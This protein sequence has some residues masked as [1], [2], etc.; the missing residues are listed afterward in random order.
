MEK[1]QAL[2]EKLFV[3]P[4]NI[5]GGTERDIKAGFSRFS[6]NQLMLLNNLYMLTR[7]RKASGGVP[8]K[9][10]AAGLEVTPATAS[11]MVETLVRRGILAR[12]HSEVDRRAVE[13][14]L[15]K[16]WHDIFRS[17]ELAYAKR[18]DDFFAARPPEERRAFE[19]TVDALNAYLA[20]M[21][22]AENGSPADG[23]GK[24]PQA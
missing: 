1:P 13:I 10:L 6:L 17:H 15:Q 24:E 14:S 9:V 4:R 12:R 19:A 8:L 18:V 23:E 5:R 16:K 21:Q 22:E 3:L 11:E 20:A 7:D 2:W